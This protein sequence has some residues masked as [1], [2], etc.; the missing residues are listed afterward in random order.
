MHTEWHLE[1]QPCKWITY[2]SFDQI[3]GGWKGATKFYYSGAIFFCPSFIVEEADAV[4]I[5]V[6]GGEAALVLDADAPTIRLFIEK[7]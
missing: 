7:L 6:V 2:H 3:E 1:H 5:V 4:S